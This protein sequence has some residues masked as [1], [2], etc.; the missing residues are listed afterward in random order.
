MWTTQG[1]VNESDVEQKLLA[2]LLMESAGLG[3]S[4]TEV[5]TK[6][7]IAERSIGKRKGKHGYVPDYLVYCHGLPCLVIEAKNPADDLNDAIREGCAYSL[8]INRHFA[9]EHNPIRFVVA[10]NGDQ[11]AWTRWDAAESITIVDSNTLLPG[12][13]SLETLRAELGK[14]S[15]A[16]H[17]MKL[18]KKIYPST[19]WN[20]IRLAGGTPVQN[21]TRR[22]NKFAEQLQPLIARFMAKDSP[23]DDS[24]IIE[25]GYVTSSERTGYERTLESLLRDN[26]SQKLR[27]ESTL[28]N[29]SPSNELI[30][31]KQF[32]PPLATERT[33]TLLIGGVG[34]GKSLFLDRFAHLHAKELER[35]LW[36]LIDF[37]GA[38]ADISA[39]GSWIQSEFIKQC[40]DAATKLGED[41][42]SLVFLKKLFGQRISKKRHVLRGGTGPGAMNDAEFDKWVR[43]EI[44]KWSDDTSSLLEGYVNHFRG[45]RGM[46][47]ILVFDNADKRTSVEQIG[48]FQHALSFAH[49]S[50][51]SSII[52][53]RDETYDI[54]AR[55][56]PLDTV[57]KHRLFRIE[58]PRLVDV[59]SKRID[60]MIEYLEQ[61]LPRRLD[62]SL[63]N[64][65]VVQYGRDELRDFIRKV[66][67]DIFGTNRRLRA[68]V[69]AIAGKD[70]RKA[71]EMFTAVLVSPYL[72]SDHVGF[73]SKY[74][75][76]PI[77]EK[78]VLRALLRGRY[79]FYSDLRG[80]S[81]IH[82]IYQVRDDRP[83]MSNYII[84]EMLAIL[85][86]ARKRT[87]DLG[88]EGYVRV[89]HL[90]AAPEL[91]GYAKEDSLWAARYCAEQGLAIAECAGGVNI[92]EDSH[93]KISSSG[94]YHLKVLN[95]REEYLQNVAM[96]TWMRDQ[97]AASDITD[98]LQVMK[99][100]EGDSA[101]QS[102]RRFKRFARYLREEAARHIQVASC[103]SDRLGGVNT[104]AHAL[105]SIEQ[106]AVRQ[107]ER[108][109][110]HSSQRYDY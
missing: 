29:T 36:L 91:M 14:D 69:E 44:A 2:P 89:D 98:S 102:N 68:M 46:S 40:R 4:A 80:E 38:P 11:L 84:P 26:A 95:E 41:P 60:M 67:N 93:M 70:I 109:L 82:N 20:P 51:C 53:M 35:S 6:Q 76:K 39:F 56:P 12:S 24:H 57:S 61:S 107:R 103:D 58:P 37:N 3:Y 66:F 21:R 54:Y 8:E 96:S 9:P 104:V 74:S 1:L 87:G 75:D 64:G 81:Y 78:T 43:Q 106:Y 108:N 33:T 65:V 31:R 47:L 28:L 62:Y 59:V 94:F 17:A 63:P 77:P 30:V 49:Q 34:A 19:W 100:W 48:V 110:R 45:E 92:N 42:D 71:L 13:N 79:A 83:A 18:Y 55:Q 16:H 22:W 73:A 86:R 50:G 23:R 90:L 25:R 32:S 97:S 27:P 101:R 15:I 99:E 10:C 88:I 105:E 5:F 7:Y 52:A 85:I 72:S